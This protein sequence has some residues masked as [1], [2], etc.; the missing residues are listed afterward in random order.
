MKIAT[1]FSLLLF[2]LFI[3]F[4]LVACSLF[5]A[6]LIS[7][8]RF[9]HLQETYYMIETEAD[10]RQCEIYLAHDLVESIEDASYVIGMTSNPLFLPVDQTTLYLIAK[11]MGSKYD[12][13]N[14]MNLQHSLLEKAH[15]IYQRQRLMNASPMVL[16]GLE[17]EWTHWWNTILLSSYPRHHMA[18]PQMVPQEIKSN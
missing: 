6:E 18:Q 15:D 8:I 16:Q 9:Y 12:T 7:R 5:P 2:L 10:L 3:C 4:H 14:V 1:P 13:M 17:V 11:R